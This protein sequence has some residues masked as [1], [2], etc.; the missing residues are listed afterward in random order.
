MKIAL[1]LT[2][3]F[4]TFNFVQESLF[5]HVINEWKPDIFFSSP[6]TLFATPEH[7]V[8]EFHG[9]HSQ[10]S[11]L[12]KPEVFGENLTSYELREYSAQFYKD[13][14][15][16]NGLEE[17]NQFGQYHW[18]ILSQMDGVSLSVNLFK[19]HVERNNITYDAVI[20][21]RADIKYYS[22]L[23]LESLP[24]NKLYYPLHSV[25]EGHVNTVSCPPSQSLD[26]P[27]ND[28]IIVGSQKDVLVFT[29]LY[30]NIITYAKEGICFNPETLFGIH[31]QKNNV[32]FTGHN[33]V[34]Y[35]L[36]RHGKY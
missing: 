12:V 32:E 28:Q 22:R 2:G 6:K 13:Q 14:I 30:D 16:K 31:C 3:F 26:R 35:E 20:L 18:R 1:I 9:I 27:Y 15:Y 10:N 7:E 25:V 17:K 4:R 29:S 24:L 36:W 34:L 8:H 21:T 33:Y 5:Q 11:E 23:N 19:R